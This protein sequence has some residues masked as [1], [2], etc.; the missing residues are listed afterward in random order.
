[1]RVSL[2]QKNIE[3]TPPL[4]EYIDRTLIKRIEKLL[5]ESAEKELPI[6]DIEIARTTEHH[7]KGNVFRASASLSLG[8][9][10][11]YCSADH[12]N[13]RAACD[14]LEKELEQEIKKFKGKRAAL[15]KRR[16]RSIKKDIRFDPAA[17][18][19]RKGRIRN[20]GN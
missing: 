13:T 11:L 9:A 7:K 18:R 8:S 3:I 20:E 12:E 14:V 6:L 1:M 15:D 4:A 19:F 10:R 2:R 5:T 17:R 16:A